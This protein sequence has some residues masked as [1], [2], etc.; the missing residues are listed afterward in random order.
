MKRVFLFLMLGLICGTCIISC[1]KDDENTNVALTGITVNQSS[2]N[3]VVGGQQ[4]VTATPVPKEATGV[5][6]T[7]SSSDENVATV[8]SSGIIVAKAVG[9]ATITV[10]SGNVS[11]T[12][13]VTV[14]TNEV[15][16]NDITVVP[17]D[18]TGAVDDTVRVRTT[19]SPSSAT[20]VSITYASADNEIATVDAGGLITITGVGTTTVTVT[21]NANSGAKSKTIAITG[22]IKSVSAVDES[23]YNS[24]VIMPGS[25]VQL[26]AVFDPD[27][28]EVT[29]VWRSTDTEVATV[30]QTGLVRVIGFGN[31]SII[32]TVGDINGEYA[33]STES[34]L[35]DA[36]GYWLFD[37][38]NDLGKALI[39]EDLEVNTEVVTAVDGPLAGNGAVRGGFQDS[40]EPDVAN[41]IWNHRLQGQFE[42]NTKI[43][44]YTV[45]MDIK[46]PYQEQIAV[47][48][49]AGYRQIWDPIMSSDL[50]VRSGLYILWV[51]YASANPGDERG[52]GLAIN[53][54][55]AYRYLV[56][57]KTYTEFHPDVLTGNEKWYRFIFSLS[58][59]PGENS[60]KVYAFLDGKPNP[61]NADGNDG[62]Y[63][64]HETTDAY[65][66]PELE[67]IVDN[68][69]YFMSTRKSDKRYKGNYDL[70]AL[71]V[72]DRVLSEEEVATL[73]SIR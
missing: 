17:A 40:S 51:D 61:N 20:G 4:P 46:V 43:W 35:A 14:T 63:P 53:I 49:A 27:G 23:G 58:Y 11:A 59:T 9:T 62:T 64:A 66:V 31:A 67:I 32:A 21:G 65:C 10:S 1:G 41:I 52:V 34:P 54:T 47:D 6:F 8:N 22:T 24:G 38:P 39:G 12:V 3:L 13:S 60:H 26:T 68:P 15:P 57:D 28:A 48:A 29:A 2:L 70:A 45:M 73:G 42:D 44:N 18:F 5:S 16:L 55:G 69:L 50:G 7:W 56:Q 71:A 25:S 19:I 33:L 37:D 36:K 72:W 30:D